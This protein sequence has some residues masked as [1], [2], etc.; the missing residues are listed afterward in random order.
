M[1]L[2]ANTMDILKAAAK[3]AGDKLAT[4]IRAYDVHETVGLAD[5]YFVATGETERQVNAIVEAVEDELREQFELKPVRREGRAQGRWVLVD[6]GDVVVN[7][8]H[9]EDRAFY[10][11]DRLWSD[12][13]QVDL[14][15]PDEDSAPA[16]PGTHA[17]GAAAGFFEDSEGDDAAGA[18]DTTAGSSADA[19][20][21]RQA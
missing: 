12:S 4:D 19:D 2:P 6:F 14:G 18:E 20:A 10:A 7:V 21:A 9:G 11:L 3:A 15:L 1:G 13:P 17:A 5:A 8:Q 16:H